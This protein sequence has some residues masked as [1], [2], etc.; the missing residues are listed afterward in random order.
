MDGYAEPYNYY[1]I[2]CNGD[3]SGRWIQL[4]DLH[5]AKDSPNISERIRHNVSL[6]PKLD[7]GMFVESERVTI[8]ISPRTCLVPEIRQGPIHLYNLLSGCQIRVHHDTFP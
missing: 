2:I 7:L 8:F 1:R 6:S 4:D 5:T 3:R